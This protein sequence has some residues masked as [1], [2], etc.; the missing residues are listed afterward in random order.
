MEIQLIIDSIFNIPKEDLILSIHKNPNW[1]QSYILLSWSVQDDERYKPSL[2]R[3]Q[4]MNEEIIS[5][6]NKPLLLFDPQSGKKFEE[7]PIPMFGIIIVNKPPEWNSVLNAAA[8]EIQ[9][10]LRFTSYK[11]ESY[12]KATSV[13]VVGIA[14]S[15]KN[16]MEQMESIFGNSSLKKFTH[17]ELIHTDKNKYVFK[18]DWLAFPLKM[19]KEREEGE[20]KT[21]FAERLGKTSSFAKIVNETTPDGKLRVAAT[22]A[23]IYMIKTSLLYT[24]KLPDNRTLFK[25]FATEYLGIILSNE[26]QNISYPYYG[27]FSFNYKR[28]LKRYL[29]WMKIHLI[30]YSD[31]KLT[32]HKAAT[33]PL[34]LREV[35]AYVNWYAVLDDTESDS[36]KISLSEIL[37]E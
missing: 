30:D 9:T 22:Q 34:D 3:L 35:S 16:A 26:E 32:E 5:G 28:H 18:L 37:D 27:I 23:Y 21:K 31:F 7:P 14:D 29:P 13:G 4:W 2:K 1:L 17:Y 24:I 6:G 8:K 11:L 25:R 10:R 15:E 33:R 20:T 19:F 36:L 12:T